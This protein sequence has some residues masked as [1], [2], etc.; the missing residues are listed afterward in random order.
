MIR[1]D[2]AGKVKLRSCATRT[3]CVA[4]LEVPVKE[5]P[6]F[7]AMRSLLIACAAIAYLSSSSHFAFAEPSEQEIQSYEGQT[8]QLT[9]IDG[10]KSI[11]AEEFSAHLKKKSTSGR[12]LLFEEGSANGLRPGRVLLIKD[13]KTEIVAIRVLKTYPN[14]FAGK[15]VLK[16]REPELGR[17]YRALKK[18]GEK[19]ITMI[20][21]REKLQSTD[22]DVMKT[23]EELAR[24][25]APDDNELDRGIPAPKPALV[26][27]EVKPK[28]AEKPKAPE[29]QANKQMPEPL[30]T[31]DGDEL[32]SDIEI[33]EEDM[34]FEDLAVNEDLPLDPQRHAVSLNYGNLRG[35]DKDN[36]SASRDSIGIRYAYTF[37]RLPLLKKKSIQD[38][39]AAEVSL[40]YYTISN[41]IQTADSITVIPLTGTLRYNLHLNETLTV[42]GYA[43]F[44][45]NNV[46]ADQAVTSNVDVLATTLAIFGG[47]GMIRIG[48]SWAIRAD[49][50]TDLFGIGAVLKF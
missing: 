28:A 8:D 18:L 21:E 15:I 1:T 7:N 9:P 24:E 48:P 19:L 30:F 35:I 27:K 25:V 10:I 4:E 5:R 45:K 47:G 12:V 49:V 22:V 31:K 33:Q 16:F 46:Y 44:V 38:S 43:G 26:K 6:F 50:G 2:G 3:A 36:N 39:L 13:G 41:F 40:Y 34:P 42:F 23:D 14:K 17:D 29:K 11:D 32:L 37:W 20:K